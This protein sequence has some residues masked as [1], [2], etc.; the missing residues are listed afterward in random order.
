MG[1]RDPTPICKQKLN[2]KIA[3]SIEHSKTL[4]FFVL[5]YHSR[6]IVVHRIACYGLSLR[7]LI[8][9]LLLLLFWFM[10]YWY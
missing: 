4:S 8:A 5:S 7:Y 1:N 10:I 3:N 6:H 9:L 2:V